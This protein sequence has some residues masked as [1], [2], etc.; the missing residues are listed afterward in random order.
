MGAD[1]EESVADAKDSGTMG[2]APCVTQTT[3]GGLYRDPPDGLKAVIDGYQYWTG[4]LTETSAQMS[5]AVIAANW[6]VFGSV[7]VIL[8]N[9]WSKLSLLS[10]LLTLATSVIGTWLLCEGHRRQGQY[11]DSDPV[12]W[13][14]EFKQFA[15][16]KHPWPFTRF[17]EHTAS[18][19]R[20]LKAIFALLGGVFL[21]IGAVLK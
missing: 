21:I 4:R 9:V 7:H 5:Y 10:V 14:A 12:R 17:I 20:N 11:G 1:I 15:N 2:Q 16:I 6:I 13:E 19:T 8:S 18:L 3:S